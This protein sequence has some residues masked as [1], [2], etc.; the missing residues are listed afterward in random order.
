LNVALLLLLLLLPPQEYIARQELDAANLRMSQ[1]R[2]D[3]NLPRFPSE[4]YEFHLVGIVVHQ[5]SADSGHYYSFVKERVPLDSSREAMW[6]EF[7]DTNVAPFSVD[8]IP[9]ECFGGEEE[10]TIYDREK[11]I[12]KKGKRTKINNAYVLVYERAIVD[13]DQWSKC[14]LPLSFHTPP[15]HYR[16]ATSLTMTHPVKEQEERKK[17]KKRNRSDQGEAERSNGSSETED[18]NASD[19]ER[20]GND[21]SKEP[22]AVANNGNGSDESHSEPSMTPSHSSSSLAEIENSTGTP[23]PPTPAPNAGP[24]ADNNEEESKKTP[25]Q[26]QPEQ[27]QQTQEI[28]ACGNEGSKQVFSGGEMV[29]SPSF[30]A[31]LFMGKLGNVLKNK[32]R[33]PSSS[34]FVSC[35]L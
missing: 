4:Y 9:Y 27:K 19:A 23:S 34:F 12:A 11:G 2:E 24:T 32:R 28:C 29:K 17:D 35:V 30:L 25:Q 31:L 22:Q 10:V 1:D 26:Q 6:F 20:E 13:L 8:H 33:F 21:D 15:P 5:G 3:D 18:E 7:N 16:E 14:F